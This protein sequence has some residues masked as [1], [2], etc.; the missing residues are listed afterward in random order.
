MFSRSAAQL[1][2]VSFIE[3][4]PPIT[5]KDELKMLDDVAVLL[6]GFCCILLINVD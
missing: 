1:V 2:V 3:R 4:S 5:Q 6:K